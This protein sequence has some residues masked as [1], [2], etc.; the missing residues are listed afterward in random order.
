MV[1]PSELGRYGYRGCQILVHTAAGDSVE[2]TDGGAPLVCRTLDGPGQP[3]A[4]ACTY[5]SGA[6]AVGYLISQLSADSG[7]A[8]RIFASGVAAP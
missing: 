6:T 3:F 7:G 2:R 5:A 4:G 8:F 1:I